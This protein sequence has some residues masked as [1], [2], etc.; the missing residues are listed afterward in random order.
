MTNVTTVASNL[1]ICKTDDGV[2]R[3]YTSYL[4]SDGNYVLELVTR[5]PD[6]V[7]PIL[8]EVRF[9]PEGWELLKLLLAEPLTLESQK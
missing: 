5:H 7:A 9:L 1:G 8:T 3:E 6:E 4:L 2:T